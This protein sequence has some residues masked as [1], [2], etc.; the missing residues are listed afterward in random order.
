M[1]Q[2]PGIGPRQ[3]EESSDVL[4]GRPDLLTKPADLLVLVLLQLGLATVGCLLFGS[5]PP[6]IPRLVAA[7]VI[8][9]VDGCTVWPLAHVRKEVREHAPTFTYRDAAGSVVG[10][11]AVPLVGAALNHRRPTGVGPGPLPDDV[12][13]VNRCSS[14]HHFVP[15]MPLAVPAVEGTRAID[16]TKRVMRV[17]LPSHVGQEVFEHT[18]ALVDWG[19]VLVA[20]YSHGNPTAVL[21]RFGACDRLAVALAPS[22]LT[23]ATRSVTAQQLGIVHQHAN[24]AVA[25]AD[26]R[27]ALS[28]CRWRQSSGTAISDGDFRSGHRPRARHDQ[29]ITEPVTSEIEWLCHHR[30]LTPGSVI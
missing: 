17:R 4:N 30:N 6:A 16:A 26:R 21:G 20:T 12:V 7:L 11:P 22:A 1:S 23:A 9:S 3:S 27:T 10:E 5:R 19:P 29:Q 14:G 24:P 25:R 18:P 15:R 28:L 8:D 13:T 2:L